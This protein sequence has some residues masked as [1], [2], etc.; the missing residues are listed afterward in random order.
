M[1]VSQKHKYIF[2]SVPKT[3]SQTI[4][5]FLLKYDTT[6][7]WNY[8]EINGKQMRIPEHAT[9]KEIKDKIGEIYNDY[10]VIA[11]IREPLSKIVSAYFFYKGGKITNSVNGKKS[12]KFQNMLNVLFA[13]ILPFKLYALLKKV[14][15]NRSYLCDDQGVVIVNNVGRTEFLNADIERIIQKLELPFD[16]KLLQTKNVSKYNRNK[17]YIG[18]GIFK[19]ILVRKYLRDVDFYNALNDKFSIG[20]EIKES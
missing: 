5:D 17:D 14:R 13:K 11:F 2:I 9:A 10:N 19:K 12:R 18:N 4:R 20:S 16:I 8:F 15:T 1:I 7:Q 3:G 6:A